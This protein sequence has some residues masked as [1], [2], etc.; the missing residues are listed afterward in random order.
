MRSAGLSGRVAIERAVRALVPAEEDPD[1]DAHQ[2]P[3]ARQRLDRPVE[4]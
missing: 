1:S 3:S 2:A 4:T